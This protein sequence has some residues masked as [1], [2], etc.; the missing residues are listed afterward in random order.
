MLFFTPG[1][2]AEWIYQSQSG[3]IFE[4]AT[5]QEMHSFLP[6]SQF[7][8][9][10]AYGMGVMRRKYDGEWAYGHGGDLS[11]ASSAWYF[12]DKDI[13]IAMQDNDGTIISW[14]HA[15][16]VADLMRAYRWYE[17]TQTVAAEEI[18]KELLLTIYPNPVSEVLIIQNTGLNQPGRVEVLNGNGQI[19]EVLSRV[20]VLEISVE[21]W[22][23]G[24][25]WVRGVWEDKVE[26][27]PVVKQ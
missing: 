21:D 26:V 19:I 6:T 7:P 11:Y 3:A 9:N 16:I 27:I 8:G 20:D 24:T 25:Y 12:P 14:D 2:L 5:M 22:A 10:T 23:N 13:S 1:D 15:P 4:E 17:S 18:E